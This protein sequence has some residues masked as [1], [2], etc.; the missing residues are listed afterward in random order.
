MVVKSISLTLNLKEGD[1]TSTL[2]QF[3]ENAGKLLASLHYQHSVMR[4]TFILLG[5]D[6]KYR[7][8]LRSQMNYLVKIFL[9]EIWKTKQVYFHKTFEIEDSRTASKLISKIDFLA[10]LDLQNAYFLISIDKNASKYLR[11]IFQD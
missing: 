1:I 6:Q 10:K 3:L 7:D 9:S 4:R 2:L 11:L 8:L 5:V